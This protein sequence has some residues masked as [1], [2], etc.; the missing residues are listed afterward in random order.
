[1]TIN[2]SDL[3]AG[4]V[5]NVHGR[6]GQQAARGV[7]VVAERGHQDGTALGQNGR[8]ILGDR[9]KGGRSHDLDADDAQRRRDAVGDGVG[10]GVGTRRGRAEVNRATVQV[11]RDRRARRGTR[12]GGEAQRIAVGV[13]VI[14]EGIKGDGLAGVRLEEVAVRRGRQVSGLLDG[15]D[16]LSTSL[17]A[18][19]VRNGQDDSLRAGRTALIGERQGTVLTEGRTQALRGLRVLQVDRVAVGVAPVAQRLVLD[20]RTRADLDGRCTHLSRCRILAVGVNRHLH[21]GSR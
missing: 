8:V 7:V 15:H 2:E 18:L 10:E 20:L 6:D 3:E 9:R 16:E 1:M 5:L 21:A 11:R 14:L 17:R 13:G 12:N 19:V 4:S